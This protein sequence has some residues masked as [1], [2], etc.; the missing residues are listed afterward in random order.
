M[1]IERTNKLQ[2]HRQNV[3]RIIAFGEANIDDSMYIVHWLYLKIVLI[4]FVFQIEQFLALMCSVLTIHHEYIFS[5]LNRERYTCVC[6]GM[7]TCVDL[8][9]WKRGGALGIW[10]EVVVLFVL[11]NMNNE[12]VL[13]LLS[14][15]IGLIFLW[16]Q[17]ST[18]TSTATIVCIHNLTSLNAKNSFRLFNATFLLGTNRK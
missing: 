15:R 8:R 9:H 10:F 12:H 17:Q 2:L 4:V 3:I 13:Q 7:W 14:F 6:F 1:K 5:L 18:V 16:W 11:M